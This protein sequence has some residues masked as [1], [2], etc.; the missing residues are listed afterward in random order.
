MSFIGNLLNPS[1]GAGFQA[2]GA[3]QG[4]ANQLY[5]Q[6]QTGLTQQQQFLNALQ[7]QNGIQNQSNVFNQLQNVAS[8]QGPNPAQAI[9]ANATGQN[10]ANQAALMAGQRGAGQNVGLIARQ[11]AQQGATN[12][13]NAAGQAAALQAQQS[14]GALN[15][16]GGIAGQQV[17][18]QANATTGYNQAVQSEQQNILN[19]LQGQNSVNG[20]IANTNAGVQGGLFSG[21][22]GGAG[23]ALGLAHGGTV[24]H[25]AAGGPTSFIGKMFSGYNNAMGQEQ[26]PQ[27][28]GAQ[29]AGSG[30]AST[31]KNIF[32]GT[33][34]QTA[35]PGTQGTV[36]VSQRQ[37]A[38]T[39]IRNAGG[40]DA[41]QGASAP[42]T[43]LVGNQ[44][45]VPTEVS[46]ARGGKIH[47]FRTGGGVPGKAKVKGDSLKNDII[48][49]KL[50][51]G[52]V[53]IPR[54]VMQSRDPV[55]GASDFVAAIMAKNHMPR[56]RA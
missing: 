41:G 44:V 29:G 33:P 12:Q 38:G 30:I 47:D 51:P 4:Q 40:F 17:A 48:P 13:Q 28:S 49:A 6:A 34:A 52:E 24:P 3:N 46:A 35:M 26:S 27:F 32:S 16:L 19:S 2:Q 56:K 37:G 39:G 14:L 55:R 53:V 25:F 18:Q 36:G 31:L 1:Q 45:S 54:S 10:T 11:A 43:S 9:L 22:L 21:L 20:Q 7:A 15:Q 23:S 8:G 50:S 5:G 42:S